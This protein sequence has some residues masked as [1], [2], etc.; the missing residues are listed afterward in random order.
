MKILNSLTGK[1]SLGYIAIAVISIAASI[2]SLVILNKN[3]KIDSEIS[4]FSIPALILNKD[5]KSL[6]NETKRL[7]NSWIYTPSQAEK[8]SLQ[9]LLKEDFP[10]LSGRISEIITISNDEQN[11]ADFSKT[12]EILNKLSASSSSITT[13]L[14]S[15]D[16]YA[17][18]AKVDAALTIYDKTILPLHEENSK[19]IQNSITKYSD[20][21][22]AM[23]AKK[24]TSY[25]LF[26]WVLV[27]MLVVILAT[28]VI[29]L[30][31]SRKTIIEPINE[32]KEIINKLG[33]GEIT[34][35]AEDRSNDEIGEMRKSIK[36]MI[37]G[38][39][40]KTDF[41][42]AIGYGNYA[43][44]YE[45]LGDKDNLGNAL[46]EMRS[47][48]KKATEED[49]K[50]SWA[51]EGLAK[52]V[53][54][55]RSNNARTA[56]LSENILTNLVKYLKANQGTMFV[57]NDEDEK[58]VRLELVACYAYDRKKHV[59]KRIEIGEGLIGQAYLEKDIIYLT[60]VPDNYVT[61]T[62]GLGDANPR[63][64]LIVPLKM[65]ERVYG[66]IEIA[67]FVPFEKY[68]IEFT[69]K[70]GESIASTIAA[71]KI[72]DRTSALLAQTQ[73]QA[74]EMR[75]QEEEMRQNMEE[76][77]A[78][79]EE[80]GRK[81]NDYIKQIESLKAELESLKA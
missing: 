24:D 37:A 7:C 25:Q 3:K 10:A 31:V 34:E 56:N 23:Q 8:Q 13:S 49:K 5:L 36:S 50:R 45:A 47:N 60:E 44:E 58:D 53:D 51:T 66:I 26:N 72:N 52:F 42:I 2:I 29:S 59:E 40:S 9:K 67:S 69:D 73:I 32:L 1:I 27:M 33:T 57:V 35:I 75:A 54:I 55:L 19:L 68:M 78:T 65:N 43:L 39:K 81:E 22:K 30:L 61:I 14:A 15:D 12:L 20:I 38:F 48:L 79:Q 28:G 6:N 64:V 74:E 46:I 71:T 41:A 11:K 70:L 62:S 76:L 80:M 4:D 16:D 63:C 17:D 18:D 21:M 77:Q